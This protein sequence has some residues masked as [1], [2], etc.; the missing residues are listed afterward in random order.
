LTLSCPNLFFAQ[1][2]DMENIGSIEGRDT[3][4]T[5]GHST[6]PLEG[7][8]DLLKTYD[9]RMVVDV[10]S[11]PQSRHN[12]QLNTDTMPEKLIPEEIEYYHVK[13]LGGLRKDCPDSPN[14]AWRNVS[15][16]EFADLRDNAILYPSIG[17]RK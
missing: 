7:F 11:V 13:G 6:R 8:V 2:Q 4:L 12:P 16:R 9:V 5:I 15:F 17:P 3:I 14:T 10:R 1:I